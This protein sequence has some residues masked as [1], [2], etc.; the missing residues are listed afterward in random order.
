LHYKDRWIDQ[1]RALI[2]GESDMA[3]FQRLP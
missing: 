3:L 1:V 2:S